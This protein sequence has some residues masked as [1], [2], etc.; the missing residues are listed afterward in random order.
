M[1]A[2]AQPQAGR[3]EKVPVVDVAER[4][5]RPAYLRG[6][7]MQLHVVLFLAMLGFC[8]FAVD[9]HPSVHLIVLATLTV[10]LGSKGS[11]WVYCVR[12]EEDG[13]DGSPETEELAPTIK[14]DEAWR[15]PIAGSCVLFGLFVVYKYLDQDIIKLLFS[16]YVVFMCMAGLG[17]NISD[18]VNIFRNRTMKPV[19]SLS[20]FEL[21][22]TLV[23][24]AG[25]ALAA[26]MGYQY[27]LTRDSYEDNWI[28]NNIF[29]VSFCLLGIKLVPISTYRT[30]AIMLI[31]L[32]FYDVFW[33]FCSKPIIG[34]NVMVT[35]AKGVKAPI[36]LMF[37]R[38]GD[39]MVAQN[40]GTNMLPADLTA[41]DF[42]AAGAHDPMASLRGCKLTC[43]DTE[44]C[45]FMSWTNSTVEADEGPGACALFSAA[46]G[47][48]AEAAE[49]HLR[50]YAK[51]LKFQPS[52]LG[53]GDIVVPGIFLALLDKWDTSRLA[54]SPAAE[55]GRHTYFNVSMVAYVLSLV[56]T[57]AAMIMFEAA[58]PAL[59]YIVPFVLVASFGLAAWRGEVSNLWAFE[60]IGAEEEE[61]EEESSEQTD[62]PHKD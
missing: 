10:V 51:E 47:A 54:G 2:D 55:S 44:A 40:N 60:V 35:V 14:E 4:P 22:L 59:L 16:C 52:M 7:L 27:I 33:V 23:D 48:A 57:L 53:L 56:A 58:Q 28:I 43:L 6:M 12:S 5:V 36:K 24:I 38:M 1:S 18:A 19:I 20:Y 32:F 42:D 3:E 31:G 21:D 39:A 29:G 8:F 11:L 41:L 26:V 25:Y 50:F 17:A 30:G 62:K 34:S 15:F 46:A 61:E 45:K 9:V 37:P 13:E 49:Q